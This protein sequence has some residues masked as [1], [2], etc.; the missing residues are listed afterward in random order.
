MWLVTIYLLRKWYAGAKPKLRDALYNSL[1]PLL[2]TLLVF[3]VIFIQCIP[4]MLVAITLSAAQVTGFL[5][6]PFYALV[7]FIFAALMIAIT[8]YLLSSS[9]IAL[10][11]VTVPGVYP[12]AALT[13][14]SDLMASRRLKLIVRILYLLFVAVIIF[15][16]TMLPIMLI[17]LWLK[18]I[19]GWIANIPIVPF[20]LLI[21]TCFIFIY[22]ATYLYRYY[23]W[24]LDY[25]E[26]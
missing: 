16:I 2:S 24:L 21:V 9:L 5:S 15:V 10:V 22:A 25:K 20:C 19:W 12:M 8:G 3:I 17:D 23:R 6:T 1:S 18:S 7:Y 26:Q 13:T 4:A 11:A 14:A